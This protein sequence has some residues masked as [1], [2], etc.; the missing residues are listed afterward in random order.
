MDLEVTGCENVDWT[1]LVQYRVQWRSL[2]STAINLRV[3]QRTGNSL[4]RLSRNSR[5]DTVVC[6]I[7]II[8]SGD[9][10]V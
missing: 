4:P 7:K 10:R 1:Q 5:H 8:K 6:V 2:S 3:A 9:V